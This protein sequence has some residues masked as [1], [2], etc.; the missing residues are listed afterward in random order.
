MSTATA[1]ATNAATV[2]DFFQTHTYAQTAEEFDCSVG[3][4]WRIVQAAD[5]FKNRERRAERTEERKQRTLAQF[6]ELLDQTVTADVTAFLR[7]L[8]D[9][10][11]HIA[12]TSP[13]YNLGKKYADLPGDTMRALYYEGWLTCIVSELARVLKPGGSVFMQIGM[14]KDDD[15]RR[16]PLDVL[17][18]PIMR[19]ANLDYQSRIVWPSPH[20]LTPRRRVAERYETALIF[21]KPGAA[22][23]FN[24]TPGR[25]PQKY[26]GKR[27]FHGPRLGELTGHALGGHPTDL[28]DDVKHLRHN[29]GEK[30]V[31]HP[32]QF[33]IAIARKAILMYSMP[34]DVV[35]DPF[36]GSG[37]T[38]IAA[39]QTSRHFIGADLFYEEVRRERLAS[40]EPDLLS[41]LPGV[42]DENMAV[43]QAEARRRDVLALPFAEN[44]A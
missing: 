31:S 17:L 33:P 14:T 44:V 43:W 9:E 20:G 41:V 30:V 5:A 22:Q 19:R 4:V 8:P 40:V 10:S 36:S 7:D 29:D 11:C 34:G 2:L 15:E 39:L 16:I 35:L 25:L 3:S 18:F 27:A 13:P 38:Q 26:P 12:V 24:P 1:P 6:K 23:T 28:W 42:S 37:S 32:A 21:S